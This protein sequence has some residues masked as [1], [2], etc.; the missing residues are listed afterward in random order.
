MATAGPVLA[1]Q[2]APA[3]QTPPVTGPLVWLEA[4]RPGSAGGDGRQRR[5]LTLRWNRMF[6]VI[7]ST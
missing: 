6:G 7:L 3:Q 4:E 5:L 1:Q 2:P